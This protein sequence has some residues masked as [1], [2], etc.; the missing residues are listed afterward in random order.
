MKRTTRRMIE[1]LES[2]AEP[3]KKAPSALGAK[4]DNDRRDGERTEASM[5]PQRPASKTTAK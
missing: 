4:T 2:F 3:P 5:R 1:R